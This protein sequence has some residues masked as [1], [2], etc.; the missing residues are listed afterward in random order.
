MSK[1]LKAFT[2]LIEGNSRNAHQ[3]VNSEPEKIKK[4]EFKK[5]IQQS[6][7]KRTSS[8]KYKHMKNLP[9]SDMELMN[10]KEVVPCV[11]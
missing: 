3:K 5:L 4:S 6:P 1:L 7:V 11:Y 9:D 10:D 8:S 2:D